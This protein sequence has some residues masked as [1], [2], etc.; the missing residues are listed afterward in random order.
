MA[1]PK[2]LPSGNWNIKPYSHTE[3]VD[4]K[5][6]RIYE[7]FTAEKK[8]EV[9]YMAAEFAL[10]KKR[11][12]NNR[13]LTV[14]EATDKYI[15]S[16]DG[17]LS[18]TTILGYKKIRNNNVANLMNMYLRDLTKDIIQEEINKEA[19]RVSDRTKKPFS[20]KTIANIHG[21]IY[22]VLDAYYP[23]L[24]IKTTLPKKEKKLIELPSVE[25]I[26]N[27]IKGTEI[28]LPCLLAMWLS[29]SMSEVRGIRIS[30]ISADGYISIKNVVVDI[31]GKP[32]EKEKTKAY[33]RTRKTKIPDY[34][35]ELIKRQETYIDA[36]ESGK[37]GFLIAM[38]G[39]GIFN[40]F[41]TIQKHNEIPHT[42]FHQLRHMN[43]SVMLQLGIPN[44]YA[45]ERG[46]WVTDHTLKE[47]Y[48]HTFS[49][50]RKAV[51]DK[52]N[53]YFNQIIESK[54]PEP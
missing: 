4:G 31:N 2:Q 32:V 45:M 1:K 54:E 30:S 24:T 22:S 34:I 52:I 9:E 12:S 25:M 7:S 23:E 10:N 49:G 44:K 28:E 13:N 37:D 19:K 21:L 46:G 43:A 16:K 8:K 20:A 6:H 41:L 33:A 11:K 18:P 5:K 51:D 29:Y 53:S 27:A 47:V 40:R 15:Q 17:I 50:E 48:Q 14:G 36:K 26:F 42:T 35:F 38:S 3:I 39:K